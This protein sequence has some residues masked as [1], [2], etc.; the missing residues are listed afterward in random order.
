M[1][2][3][4]TNNERDLPKPAR[5]PETSPRMD[6]PKASN[7]GTSTRRQVLQVIDLMREDTSSSQIYMGTDV[8][9]KPTFCA[10]TGP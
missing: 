1:L 8:E 10:E 7:G 4:A 9:T 6:A 2:D 5:R 3:V